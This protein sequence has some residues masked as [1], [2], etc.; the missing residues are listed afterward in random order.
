MRFLVG[1]KV[2]GFKSQSRSGTKPFRLQRRPAHASVEIADSA[3]LDGLCTPRA[4]LHGGCVQSDMNAHTIAVALE[5]RAGAEG[6]AFLLVQ[7]LFASL[8]CRH[9][10]GTWH[11]SLL[12]LASPRTPRP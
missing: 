2:S 11:S 8:L 6:I 4:L 1:P 7:L 12:L 5:M 3:L 10:A 9:F